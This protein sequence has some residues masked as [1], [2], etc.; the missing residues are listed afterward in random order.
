MKRLIFFFILS[1][2]MSTHVHAQDSIPKGFIYNQNI[3]TYLTTRY[4]YGS[5]GHHVGVDYTF[6]YKFN[7]FTLG[8]SKGFNKEKTN[9]FN[10]ITLMYGFSRRIKYTIFNISTGFGYNIGNVKN[11]EQCSDADSITCNILP[12][13]EIK[14]PSFPLRIEFTF[15]PKK[16]SEFFG[17][18]F[19]LYANINGGLPYATGGLHFVFGKVSPRLSE[20]QK[21]L[22]GYYKPK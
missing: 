4:G 3:F 13:K 8:Y 22:Q 12:T 6:K 17:W 7:L 20:E 9:N 21:I 18:G 2:I 11:G 5:I 1:C 16:I 19:H 15:T 10:E 14:G